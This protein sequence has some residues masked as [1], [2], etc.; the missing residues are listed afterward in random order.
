MPRA[1]RRKVAAVAALATLLGGGAAAVLALGG[2]EPSSPRGQRAVTTAAGGNPTLR[3]VR[4]YRAGATVAPSA[5]GAVMRTVHVRGPFPGAGT[6]AT[7]LTD[8]KCAPDAAGISRCLNKLRLADGRV[9]EVRHPHRM[10][11][12]ACMSPGERVRVSAA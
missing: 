7:V 5:P 12:V 3:S 9:I 4:V 2:A 10:A 11:V 6:I 1:S 8:E